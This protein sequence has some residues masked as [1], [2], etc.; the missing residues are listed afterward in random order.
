M[1]VR[2]IPLGQQPVMPWA[3]GGGSTRQVAID[4]P[5]A[6]MATGFRWRVSIAT[7]ARGGPFSALPG[8]DRS[9]WLLAGAGVR[10]DC[11][12]RQVVLDR[13]RQRFDFG[14]ETPITCTLLAG[15]C[16]DLNVMAARSLVRADADLHELAP[17][18]VLDLP[19][20]PQRLLLALRGALSFDGGDLVAERDALRIDDAGRGVLHAGAEGCTVLVAAFVPR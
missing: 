12:D 10:L 6:S 7:V 3:N 2:R 15:P 19:A 14:G 5:E 11:G 13:A 17:H 1:N 16:E 20:A 9:T 4:P 18:A 8:V